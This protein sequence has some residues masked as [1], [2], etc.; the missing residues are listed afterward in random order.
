MNTFTQAPSEI[1]L[2]MIEDMRMRKL[3]LRTRE[4][5]RRR[6]LPDSCISVPLQGLSVSVHGKLD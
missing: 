3:E 6:P 2:R 1:R 4:G 5:Y